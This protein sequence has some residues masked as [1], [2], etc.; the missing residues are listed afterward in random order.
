LRRWAIMLLPVSLKRYLQ[1]FGHFTDHIQEEGAF[2]NPAVI[3][4]IH[5]SDRKKEL[6]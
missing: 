2:E 6:E 5:D 3:A 4:V 1:R